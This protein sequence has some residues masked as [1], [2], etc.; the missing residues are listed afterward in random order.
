MNYLTEQEEFWAGNFGLDYMN[1]NQGEEMVRQ[2]V[3]LFSKILRY[4][5]EA[6][7]IAELGCNIGM[8]LIALKRISMNF[9]LR[10]YEINLE[11]SRRAKN[12]GIA[13]IINTTI[14]DPLATE[15]TF[16]LVFTKGV[17]IHISPNHLNN[18]YDNLYSLSHRYIL[19][20]E[21]YS[22]SPD[23]VTYRGHEDRLFKRDFA[24]EL[25]DKYG[26]TL[27]AYGFNYR[28]DNYIPGDD[29][30]WFLLKKHSA[31]CQDLN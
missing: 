6:T 1:R 23:K 24:G 15:V 20:S 17:L 28:R 12:L 26:L 5:P 8:N 25:I 2:N 31:G 3:N 7:S 10:G 29:G 22:P 9:K 27:V 11:A 14:I 13:E 18:V 30:T 16:D 4:A 21:Y 19:V